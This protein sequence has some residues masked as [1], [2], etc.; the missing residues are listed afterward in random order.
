MAASTASSHDRSGPRRKTAA[1][2]HQIFDVPCQPL[3]LEKKLG[4]GAFGTV[5]R[6]RT[7][8]GCVVAIKQVVEDEN[9]VNREAEVCK[10]L[11]AGNHPNI[12]EVKG[13]YF[14]SD[15]ERTMN[16]VMEH[17][18]QTMRSVLSFLSERDMRMK[19]AHVQIYM[20]Q[21]ARA[22]LFLHQQGVVHRSQARERS[23]RSSDTQAE[24]R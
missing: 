17:M 11:A 13:I 12:V 20:Y 3:P 16:L 8:C 6:S 21:L 14:T 22:L 15:Q 7:P 24:A 10:M 18:P 5:F 19:A 9:F 23:S 4:A 1:E 2:I